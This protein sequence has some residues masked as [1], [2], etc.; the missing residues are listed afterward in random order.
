VVPDRGSPVT[1]SGRS[2]RL[3][4]QLIARVVAEEAEA[5]GEQAKAVGRGIALVQF[6]ERGGAQHVDGE[7]EPTRKRGVPPIAEAG[8]V[9]SD[10]EELRRLEMMS[11][12]VNVR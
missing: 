5:I 1:N 9:L 8:L 3:R 10:V 6:V 2:M 7:R 11:E 12:R 4:A